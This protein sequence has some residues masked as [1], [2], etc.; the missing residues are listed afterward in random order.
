[1]NEFNNN[2]TSELESSE[3]EFL[4]LTILLLIGPSCL[5]WD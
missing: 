2:L 5:V 1:M 4:N 3:D